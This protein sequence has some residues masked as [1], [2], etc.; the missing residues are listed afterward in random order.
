M[1]SSDSRLMLMDTLPLSK[2]DRFGRICT[3]LLNDMGQFVS[4][5]YP[6]RLGLGRVLSV[7][8]DHIPAD[9]VSVGVHGLGRLGGSGVGVDSHFAEVSAESFFHRR[10]R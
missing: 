10:S 4:E 5:Q 2:G 9:R 7:R 8:E 6:A 3:L 1:I